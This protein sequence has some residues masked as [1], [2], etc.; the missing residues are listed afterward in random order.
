[1][2]AYLELAHRLP[3]PVA[4]VL[5][6]GGSWGALQLGMLQAL[7]RTDLTPDLV[8]GTSV[9]SL[10][11]AILAADPARAV[12][13]L[14]TIWP[15]VTR[16]DIFPG[17][18]LRGLRTL[19]VTRSWIFDNAPLTDQLTATLPVSTFEELV[20]PFVAVATDFGTGA[21]AELDSGD[22]R[23]ALLASSAIPG[24]YPSVERDGRRLVDGALVANVPI[25]VALERGAQSLVVLDCGLQGVGSPG[26]ATSLVEVL[27]QSSAILA[28]GQIA[29]DLQRCAHLP[30]VWLSRGR[31]NT[32]TLLDFSQTTALIEEGFVR[33]METL[34]GLDRVSALP[35]GL[36]GAPAEFEQHPLI[37]PHVA[38][39]E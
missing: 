34:H 20:V 2:T 15:N 22:L 33:S 10:N 32:T 38:P 17:G 27:A 28:R 39:V 11:G 3:R 35:P 16:H 30:M 19:S 9:G 7:A 13:R 26:A 6:G 25:T 29:H 21:T 4:F 12:E 24:I 14:E 37:R 1:M 31:A 18:V 23:S 5:G 8:V 36:Y